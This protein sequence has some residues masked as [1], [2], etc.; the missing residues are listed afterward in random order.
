MPVTEVREE[1]GE[2]LEDRENKI[3]IKQ[4]SSNGDTG[5]SD[6]IFPGT[7]SFGSAKP[8]IKRTP[9]IDRSRYV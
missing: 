3:L 2:G 7:F 5:V 8:L 4:L 9:Y 1:A 6:N